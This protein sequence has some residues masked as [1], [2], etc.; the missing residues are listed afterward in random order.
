MEE[1]IIINNNKKNNRLFVGRLPK[2]ITNTEFR[3]FFSQFGKLYDASI[4]FHHVTGNPCR[5]GYVSYI[6]PE[7]T[8]HVLELGK[9]K[10]EEEK[11]FGFGLGRIVMRGKICEIKAAATGEKGTTTT[12]SNNRLFVGGLPPDCCNA[13]LRDFFQQFGVVVDS[14]VIVHKE[15]NVPRGFGSVTFSD[16]EVSCS[17]LKIRENNNPLT[18]IIDRRDDDN[19]IGRIVMRGCACVIQLYDY[20]RNHDRDREIRQHQQRKRSRSPSLSLSKNDYNDDDDDDDDDDGDNGDNGD[21]E[22]IDIDRPLNS[23][24]P[25]YPYNEENQDSLT[26]S[27]TL[28]LSSTVRAPPYYVG[29]MTKENNNNNNNNNKLV[30]TQCTRFLK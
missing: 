9:E 4:T 19:R 8:K 24:R 18:N 26:S 25:R 28:A 1:Q 22:G 11:L 12:S 13:E 30:Y 10:K 23:K 15:N 27:T 7:V 17:I 21:G 16:P 29:G 20:G 14:I 6:D 5:F 3:L 2:D